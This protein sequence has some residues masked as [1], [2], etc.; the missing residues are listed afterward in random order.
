[1]SRHPTRLVAG[2][3]AVLLAACGAATTDE[4]ATSDGGAAGT[5]LEGTEDCVDADLDGGAPGPPDLDE[6]PSPDED[7]IHEA[8]ELLGQPEAEAL[9]HFDDV[10]LGRRDG[11]E[12]EVTDDHQPGRKTIATQEDGTGVHRVVEVVVETRDG[13][14]TVTAAS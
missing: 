9:E 2:V 6:G 4:G 14:E 13:Q 3:I 5:C 10:R 1:M 11:E 7:A 12:F 8:R